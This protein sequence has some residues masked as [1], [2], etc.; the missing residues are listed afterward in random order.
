MK[1]ASNLL[2]VAFL[3]CFVEHAIALQMILNTRDP[4][5]VTIMPIRTGVKINLNYV[6]SGV[7]EE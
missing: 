5:C 1:V 7:N 3:C 2:V 4:H 6:V